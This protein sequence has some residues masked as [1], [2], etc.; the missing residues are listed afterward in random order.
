MALT[1]KALI[2]KAWASYPILDLM[3]LLKQK[4][5]EWT[6]HAL[7][8]R[9]EMHENTIRVMLRALEV[10]GLAKRR[11]GTPDPDKAQ[12]PAEIWGPGENL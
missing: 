7:M 1:S 4:D 6:I 9:M 8:G 2:L 12:R 3:L 5:K 10:R 11:N